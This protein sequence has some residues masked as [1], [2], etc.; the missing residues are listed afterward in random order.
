MRQATYP[1]LH[2]KANG[3]QWCRR[4]RDD[5]P[6]TK[7]RNQAHG[8]LLE[9]LGGT[10]PRNV[11]ASAIGYSWSCAEDRGGVWTLGPERNWRL[12]TICR[13]AVRSAK[14]WRRRHCG[15]R[16]LRSRVGV[17]AEGQTCAGFC[18]GKNAQN[19]STQPGG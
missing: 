8:E 9:R 11:S 2:G 1:L 13:M 10:D 6:S 7:R 18:H 12:Q 15:F 19:R 16:M 4:P 17:V 3:C 14:K 5:A